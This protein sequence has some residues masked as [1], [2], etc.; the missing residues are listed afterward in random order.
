MDE[1]EDDL[2]SGTAVVASFRHV[3]VRLGDV[4]VVDAV[5]LDVHEGEWVSVIGPNGAGKTSLLRA[6]A[7]IVPYSG[8]L[9]VAGC[10]PRR[11]S[12]RLLARHVSYVPQDPHMPS[13]MMVGEYVLLGRTAYVSYFGV[14]SRRDVEVVR[15][16]LE[17][18]DL[19]EFTS[20]YLSDLSG[21]ERQR[22][23][24]A[25]ALAQQAPVL[26]MDE[27]TTALDLGHQHHVLELVD[28]LRRDRGLAVI[29]AVHDLTLAGQFADRLMLLS[30]G[31]ALAT[32]PASDVLT[33]ELISEHWDVKVEIVT[34]S[35]GTLIVVP[36]RDSSR[37]H[38]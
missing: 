17:E 2:V 28:K 26:L 9:V 31:R 34:D 24:L 12:S 35:S 10:Q 29:T 1:P 13:G 30:K 7:G 25:R 21:G 19:T 16:V 15:D 33:P 18:L 4:D 23:V 8:E 22:A 38:A 6:A 5:S 27:P 37:A 14:E 36:R 3:T 20:R 11:D 32:G